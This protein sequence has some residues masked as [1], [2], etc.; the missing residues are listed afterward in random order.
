MEVFKMNLGIQ[1]KPDFGMDKQTT[2]ETTPVEEK[3]VSCGS[4]GAPIKKGAEKCRWCHS[5]VK[6][7]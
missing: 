5:P 6:R 4:C 3:K 1:E 2:R 7:Q